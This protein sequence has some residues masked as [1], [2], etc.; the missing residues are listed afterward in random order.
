MKKTLL[1]LII[2]IIIT[3]CSKVDYSQNEKY[4]EWVT[5]P[6]Y[7]NGIAGVG[8]AKI[9]E[10]GFDFARKEAM[11]SAR[12]DLARQ[13]GIKIN[14][15]FKSYIARSGVDEN[16]AVDRVVEEVYNDVVSEEISG[17]RLEKSWESPT[18]EFFVLMVVDNENIIKKAAESAREAES[19]EEIEKLKTPE[20]QD[21]LKQELENFFN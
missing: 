17:S 13:I 18:G 4:P 14:S 5:S 12:A 11:A 21:E 2:L 6:T 19:L 1:S 9:T 20:A 3:A 16:S 10:L 8:S 7:E 15:T